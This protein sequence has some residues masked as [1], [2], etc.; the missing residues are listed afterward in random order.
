[1][2][3]SALKLQASDIIDKIF[4]LPQIEHRL[5]FITILR[6]LMTMGLDV[7]ISYTYPYIVMTPMFEI[8]SATVIN[9]L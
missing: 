8:E 1:M 9:Y 6:N 3:A 4:Q 2:I 7:I 5:R